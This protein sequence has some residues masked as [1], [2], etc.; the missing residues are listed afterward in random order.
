LYDTTTSNLKDSPLFERF[1]ISTSL[2]FPTRY[3]RTL[4]LRST[5]ERSVVGHV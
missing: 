4:Y 1:R 2:H 3:L 5:K